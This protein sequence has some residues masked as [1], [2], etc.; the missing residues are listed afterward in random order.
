MSSSRSVCF[1]LLAWEAVVT[2]PAVGQEQIPAAPAL[3]ESIASGESWRFYRERQELTYGLPNRAWLKLFCAPNGRIWLHLTDGLARGRPPG[4]RRSL[5]TVTGRDWVRPL[6]G[7]SDDFGSVHE[8]IAEVRPTHPMLLSLQ[9]GNGINVAGVRGRYSFPAKG[10]GE[11]LSSLIRD[12]TP[13][14]ARP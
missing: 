9:N 2:H 8:F 4:I 11:P 3:K 6:L 14:E 5:V 1:L 7:T 12:C 13:Q 10:A